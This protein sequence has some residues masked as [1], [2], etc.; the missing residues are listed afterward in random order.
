MTR[1]LCTIALLA[2]LATEASAQMTRPQI[3]CPAYDSAMVGAPDRS[4]GSAGVQGGGTSMY[5]NVP[6]GNTV[7]ERDLG[8]VFVNLTL[9]KQ[10]SP[11]KLRVQVS[12]HYVGEEPPIDQRQGE[13]LVDDTLRF[14]LGTMRADPGAAFPNGVKTW[15]LSGAL[16]PAS[17][18]MLA[19]ARTA[20]FRTGAGSWG[21]PG[22]ILRDIRG[23]YAALLCR[24]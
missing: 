24:N 12:A 17:F 1:S 22:T 15:Y 11:A 20:T 14:D 21:Y 4:I 8:V 10:G 5:I 9:I 3:G 2:L 13:L 18:P 23:A 6:G 19:R 7:S 16:D